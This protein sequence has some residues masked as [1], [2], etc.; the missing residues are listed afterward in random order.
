[1]QILNLLKFIRLVFLLSPKHKVFHTENL[2]AR[3]VRSYIVDCIHALL[4]FLKILNQDFKEINK[5]TPCS[6]CSKSTFYPFY[7]LFLC[8][9]CKRYRGC[10]H[11]QLIIEL[12][13]TVETNLTTKIV[14]KH[15]QQFNLCPKL[16]S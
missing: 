4:D 3:S 14:L 7:P 8:Y 13:I 9:F 11:C 1:M 10:M 12:S 6:L 2:H 5:R 15:Q 16:F